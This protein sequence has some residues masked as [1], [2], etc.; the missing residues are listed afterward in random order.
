M[1]QIFSQII[2]F[3]STPVSAKK[4]CKIYTNHMSNW[5]R[6]LLPSFV[7]KICWSKS[8]LHINVI[9]IQG[10]KLGTKLCN[11]SSYDS[12]RNAP[13]KSAIP[14]END[15]CHTQY[16][17]VD[18]KLPK[19]VQLQSEVKYLEQNKVIKQRWTGPRPYLFSRYIWLLLDWRTRLC[20]HPSL[21]FP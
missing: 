18:V 1:L 14:W 20:L 8:E 11:S 4:V 12:F 3:E 7:K 15:I 17:A 5:W 2:H 16:M 9:Y 21:R 10:F 13:L 19:K 6:H